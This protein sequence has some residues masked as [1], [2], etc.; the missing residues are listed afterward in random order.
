MYKD[1]VKKSFDLYNSVWKN[2]TLF[3]SSIS[4]IVNNSAYR[5]IIDLGKRA[6]PYIFEDLKTSD[7]HWFYAL[8]SVTGQN[9]IR[10]SHRG[11]LPLMK[12]DWIQWAIENNIIDED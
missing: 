5:A 4:E 11:I 9:P 12:Q 6:L 10:E 1:H 8:E 3:S 7:N 2:E